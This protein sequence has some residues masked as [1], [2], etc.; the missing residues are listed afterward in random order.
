MGSCIHSAI[1][2]TAT[3][4]SVH[5]YH[6]RKGST[7]AS[8]KATGTLRGGGA[9]LLSAVSHASEVSDCVIGEMLPQIQIDRVERNRLNLDGVEQRDK[10]FHYVP[11]RRCRGLF[12]PDNQDAGGPYLG[13]TG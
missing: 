10:H 4:R 2:A 9:R 1:G 6:Q 12:Q 13:P 11:E 8:R 5:T 3:T 7:S